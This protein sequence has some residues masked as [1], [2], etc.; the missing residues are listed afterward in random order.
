[1]NA[2]NRLGFNLDYNFSWIDNKKKIF[3]QNQSKLLLFRKIKRKISPSF[4][5][6]KNIERKNKSNSLNKKYSKEVE[7]IK[8]NS[9]NNNLSENLIGK[10]KSVEPLNISLNDEK[11]KIKNNDI[12]NVEK[13]KFLF[14]SKIQKN[15]PVLNQKYD[16]KHNK[17]LSLNYDEKNSYNP[18]NNSFGI[19][20]INSPVKF[21][22]SIPMTNGVIINSNNNKLK[23]NSKRIIY[24][25]Y[26]SP[27]K[28]VDNKNNGI[29]TKN[30][31]VNI[32]LP[33][34]NNN[35]YLKINNKYPRTAHRLIYKSRLNI[36]LNKNKNHQ[37]I[38]NTKINKKNMI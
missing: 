6:I 10:S 34:N 7:Y 17:T 13:D 20:P 27:L 30:N 18:I 1:M 5:I 11:E 16:I 15:K 36:L 9:H 14:K 22:G 19:V 33:N 2:L 3:I 4:R 28:I 8:D 29:F 35:D 24:S 23:Y 21:I 26:N 32:Q 37:K 38:N 12:L 25:T 31:I